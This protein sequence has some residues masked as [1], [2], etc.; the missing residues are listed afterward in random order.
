MLC[1]LA[2]I[3]DVLKVH[4]FKLEIFIK[5]QINAFSFCYLI[6]LKFLVDVFHFVT[7][8]NESDIILFQ[9]LLVNFIMSFFEL[10]YLN[11]N[12]IDLNQYLFELS[13]ILDS[14]SH[15]LASIKTERYQES[16]IIEQASI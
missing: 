5:P 2:V 9:M 4:L 7:I 12:L 1:L 3:Y 11:Q 8:S 13:E 16:S 6:L 15:S 10:I 14:T